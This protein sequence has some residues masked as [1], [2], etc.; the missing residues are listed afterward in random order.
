MASGRQAAEAGVS[1]N[2][3]VWLYIAAAVLAATLLL[4]RELWTAWVWSWN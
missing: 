3:K 2:R 4:H 1:I